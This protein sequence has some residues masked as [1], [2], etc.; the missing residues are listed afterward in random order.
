[1]CSF[2][3][4]QGDQ[5]NTLFLPGECCRVVIVVSCTRKPAG[6]CTQRCTCLLGHQVRQANAAG[7]PHSNPRRLHVT[8][9]SKAGLSLLASC[10]NA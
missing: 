7:H 3:F 4:S 1:M 6:F 2:F 9:S 5:L 10:W 8:M